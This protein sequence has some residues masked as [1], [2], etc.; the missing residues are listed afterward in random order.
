ME[1]LQ[2]IKRCF[3]FDKVLYS[4]HSLKEMKNEE[5]GEIFDKEVF[6]AIKN[7]EL[8]REYLDDKPY[9]SLLIFGLT[10][11]NRPLHIVSAY[12]QDDDIAIIVT[13]YHPDPNLWI[14]YKRR[15]NK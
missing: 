9:P 2:L 14:D 1:I 11:N 7:G 6:E 13:V 12:N 3:E 5:Y 10:D 15:V 4:S 8:I